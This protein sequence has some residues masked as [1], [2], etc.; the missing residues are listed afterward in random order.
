MNANTK[1]KLEKVDQSMNSSLFT[2]ILML[3][4]LIVFYLTWKIVKGSLT[5]EDFYKSKAIMGDSNII[6]KTKFKF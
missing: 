5:L 2:R 3:V 6:N 1:K 4:M